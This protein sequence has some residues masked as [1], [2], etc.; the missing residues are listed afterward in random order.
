MVKTINLDW[1]CGI[2]CAHLF[3]S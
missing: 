2:S 1:P 3:M